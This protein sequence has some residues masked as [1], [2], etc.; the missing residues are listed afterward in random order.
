MET[1]TRRMKLQTENQRK[2]IVMEKL[3]WEVSEL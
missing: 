3:K 2:Q 1:E